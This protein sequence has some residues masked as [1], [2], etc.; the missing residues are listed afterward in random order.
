MNRSTPGLPVY[1]QL[2]EFTQTHVHQ[3]GD[4]IQP[5]QSSIIPFSS[6]PQFL[7]ASEA[8]PMSQLFAWGGQSTGV[9]ALA[10]FLPKNTQDWSSLE[11]TDW[12]SLQSKTL[13]F[14][15]VTILLMPAG[16]VVMLFDFWNRRFIAFVFPDHSTYSLTFLLNFSKTIIYFHGFC[17][18]LW[19]IF[20]FVY[21]YCFLISFLL[22]T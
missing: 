12:I 14:D 6:Y 16:S 8:L 17:T 7:P 2:P 1:H 22:L 21:F 5:S 9:L 4:A 13:L 3:V 18:F 15:S 10:S 20:Y 11:W 19:C